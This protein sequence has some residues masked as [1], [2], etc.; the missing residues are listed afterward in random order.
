MLFLCFCH[1]KKIKNHIG[2]K[3]T[4]THPNS[5]TTIGD[6]AFWGCSGLTSITI[7]ESVTSIGGS[8][9]YGTAWY[10]N[11]PN[12]VMYINKVAY[13]YK[14]K[15]TMPLGTQMDACQDAGTYL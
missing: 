2:T 10:K 5:V 9:F 12:G 14:D 8:A 6:K 3:T 11:Q 13:T 4:V 1:A 7:P 15:G